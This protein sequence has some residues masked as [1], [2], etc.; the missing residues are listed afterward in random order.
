MYFEENVG[1]ADRTTRILL[2]F[3]MIG[4]L[5]Y[6]EGPLRWVGLLGLFNTVSAT[7]LLAFVILDGW[8]K[9]LYGV[10]TPQAKLV[11]GITILQ[12]I[13]LTALGVVSIYVARIY[14][15]VVRRPLYVVRDEH[16]KQ[17]GRTVQDHPVKD[18]VVS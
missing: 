16:P 13:V 7:A 17:E 15:E 4:L 12:G 14:S 11:I 9:L 18:E 1:L 3:G 10:Y 6:L 5:V 8:L 2:G